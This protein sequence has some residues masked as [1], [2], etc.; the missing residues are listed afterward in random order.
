VLSLYG[1][2]DMAG[3]QKF[4]ESRAMLPEGTQYVVIE[5]G[6]HA[7]FGDYGEQPGDNP[8]LISR[9]EQQAQVVEAVIAFLES[10]AR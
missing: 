4:E 2:R 7:Q 1:T 10:I 6:N 3:V 9:A 5:G 8:A